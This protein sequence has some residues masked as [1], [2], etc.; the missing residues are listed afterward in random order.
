MASS[1][2]VTVVLCTYNRSKMLRDALASLTALDTAGGFRYEVLVVDN[3]STDDTRAVVGA[4]AGQS[5]APVR[6]VCEPRRGRVFARNRGIAEAGGQWI[7][8]FDDDQLADRAWLHELLATARKTGSRCVGGAVRLLLPAGCHRQLAQR[9]R[10]VLGESADWDSP[11]PYTETTY[12]GT[13]NLMLHRTVFDETGLYDESCN[14]RGEDS[15]LYRRICRAGIEAW[16]TPAAIVDHVIPPSRLQADYFRDTSLQDGWSCARRDYQDQ[17]RP[18]TAVRMVARAVQASACH[19][20][21]LAWAGLRRRPEEVLGAKCLLWRAKGYVA[22]AL[23]L[24]F[25]RLFTGPAFASTSPAAIPA[26]SSGAPR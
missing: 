1:I 6:Y 14:L 11:R 7:A 18:G 19:W 3:A 16:F 8:F 20:P 24:I 5:E 23:P 13:G 25:P 9:C 22:S 21:R 12:P 2:D 26:P 4:V 17:G 15:D 10:A